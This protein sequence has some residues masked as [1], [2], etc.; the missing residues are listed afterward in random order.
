MKSLNVCEINHKYVYVYVIAYYYRYQYMIY[1]LTHNQAILKKKAKCLQIY[2]NITT[3]EAS[4]IIHLWT[5]WIS[6]TAKTIQII[7]Y[8]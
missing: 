1:Y 7:V 4:K 5:E 6:V 2:Q 8:I 3:Y